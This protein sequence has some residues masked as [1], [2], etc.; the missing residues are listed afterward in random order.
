MTQAAF[1]LRGVGGVVGGI[2]I[3]L[4]NVRSRTC[5]KAIREQDRH[6]RAVEGAGFE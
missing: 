2:L 6:T 1:V 4:P 5:K 3:E